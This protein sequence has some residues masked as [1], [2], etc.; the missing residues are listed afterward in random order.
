MAPGGGSTIQ[1]DTIVHVETLVYDL[2]D[3]KM[4]WAGQSSTVNPSQANKMVKELVDEAG[5]GDAQAGSPAVQ[6][7][8]GPPAPGLSRPHPPGPGGRRFP[9]TAGRPAAPPAHENREKSAMRRVLIA[10]LVVASV[11]AVTAWGGTKYTSTWKAP[12]AP[13]ILGEGDKV[14]A[15]VIT[16]HEDTRNGAEA[17][18][19]QDLGKRGV[20]VV[21][22]YTVIP[23]NLI[24]DKDKARPYI[25]KTGCKYA[26]VLRVV[27]QDKELEGTGPSVSAIPV[28]MPYYSA[29]YGGYYAFGWGVTYNAGVMEIK[30]KFRVETL[31]YDL[32]TDKL[33]W[34]GMSDTT[35]PDTAQKFIKD[36]VKRDDQ[37]DEEAGPH[38]EVTGVRSGR[39]RQNAWPRANCQRLRCSPSR[40]SRTQAQS[41][42]IG[43]KGKMTRSPAPTLL[44]R[45][46]G[47]SSLAS[48]QTLPASKKTP[49]CTRSQIGKR[50]SWLNTSNRLA[51]DGDVRCTGAR[52]CSRRSPGRWW[53]PRP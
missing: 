4:I 29:F 7:V 53:P 15:L 11:P 25:D 19:A 51:P 34:A 49:A 33:I 18:L 47:F 39:R 26:L 1:T 20:T 21:P 2:A 48:S 3:G 10:A 36:L 32:G 23:P 30:N 42:R 43:P 9:T 52:G 41:R 44:R 40:G 46:P 24:R 28:A 13:P 35:N 38:Q 37:G 12:D 45:F 22:A 16:L 14:L 5:Q 50:S 31:L 6:E 17:A 27:A 8:A